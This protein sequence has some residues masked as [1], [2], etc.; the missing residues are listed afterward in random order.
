MAQLRA[1]TSIGGA[2]AAYD[3][4]PKLNVNEMLLNG[5]NSATVG[6]I[7][8]SNR[9]GQ[10]AAPDYIWTSDTFSDGATYTK[11][12]IILH[13]SGYGLS[14]GS[15]AD[16]QYHS[17]GKHDWYSADVQK[18]TLSAGGVLSSTGGYSGVASGNW[19]NE[20]AWKPTSLASATRIRGCISP[21]GGEFALAYMGGQI[22]PYTDGFFYQN[23]GQYRCIDS[24]SIASQSVSYASSTQKTK[25]LEA[26]T[27]AD[28]TGGDHYLRAIRETG[29]TTRLYMG[30]LGDTT[31]QNSIKVSYA[32]TAGSAP[33]NGGTSSYVTI[34]YNNSSNSTYQLLWGSSTSVYGT[35]G[36]YIHPSINYLYAANF[37]L[38]SDITLKDNIISI[39][40]NPLNVDYKQFVMKANPDQ[41]R[42]GVIAQDLQV[43]HPELVS[44]GAE[45]LLSVS[46]TD[47]LVREVA[48]LKEKIKELE[49]KIG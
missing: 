10:T 19:P 9:A 42:Y 17:G 3:G 32:D 27:G 4:M 12:K 33:A 18:M 40:L 28:W 43:N 23:E 44:E 6:Y 13:S 29:W 2:L 15:N 31:L 5:G 49:R 25:Q 45:G 48:Y 30:Y 37:Q 14:V 1:G 36:V 22:Y 20:G 38:A 34:N 11:M 47:L 41:I 35:A 7:K 21:D 8:T 24:N 16:V 39:P 26:F 46:Y